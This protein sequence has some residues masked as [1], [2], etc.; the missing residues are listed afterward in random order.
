MVTITV[1]T[2]EGRTR[3]LCWHGHRPALR[4]RICPQFPSDAAA[5]P[6]DVLGRVYSFLGASEVLA[7]DSCCA[8]WRRTALTTVWDGSP[9][10]RSEAAVYAAAFVRVRKQWRKLTGFLAGGVTLSGPAA[11]ADLCQLKEAVQPW[12]LP[13]LLVASLNCHDGEWERSRGMYLGARL[14]SAR[15]ISNTARRWRREGEEA[16]A[17]VGG[18]LRIPLY[19]ESRARQIAMEL[20][21]KKEDKATRS[22]RIIL[23]YSAA[24]FAPH[25]KV[26]ANDWGGFLTLI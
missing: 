10:A 16:V 25:I 11:E 21:L 5:M 18:T 20:V 3:Q 6:E 1:L 13:P 4:L 7:A 22:R 24:P 12:T 8:G 2:A 26:L 19:S 23:I 17:T 9:E 15:E 14:L